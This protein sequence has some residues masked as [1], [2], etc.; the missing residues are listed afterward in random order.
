MTIKHWL[1]LPFLALLG[2]V[3]CPSADDDDSTP[4]DDD[5]STAADDDDTT[6]DDD[7]TTADDD[8]SGDDDDSALPGEYAFRED[9]AEAF[10]RVDRKGMPAVAT[11][12]ITSKDSYNA[13]SPGTDLADF[14]GEVIAK[15]EYIH[16]GTGVANEFPG[17]DGTLGTLGLTPC[18]GSATEAS[19]GACVDQALSV[20]AFPDAVRIVLADAAG[21]PNGRGLTDTVIDV[22]LAVLLLDLSVHPVTTF[23]N[24]DG[25]GTLLEVGDS[26]NPMANDKAFSATFPY[27]AEPW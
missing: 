18:G 15:L 24:L 27:L 9:A 7:D 25:D 8:D 10:V 11:A 21:F 22:T 14:A 17:L 3:G 13:G 2:L 23:I 12:L 19:V 20:H 6:A 1:P 26:L 4:A 5:D 16:N